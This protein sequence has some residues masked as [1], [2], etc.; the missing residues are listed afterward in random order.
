MKITIVGSGNVAFVLAKL[1]HQHQHEIVE[2]CGRNRQDVDQLSLLTGSLANYSLQPKLPAE[3]Y[4]IA[5]SD[6]ALATL[7]AFDM[8]HTGIWVHSAGSI[9][10]TVLMDKASLTGVWYPLQSLSKNHEQ[11]AAIPFVLTSKDEKVIDTL[12]MLTE[13][14]G[15]QWFVATDGERFQYHIA[16][17]FVNNFTNYLYTLAADLCMDSSIKFDLLQPLIAAT[18]AR[19]SSQYPGNIQT[20]PAARNDEGT[21]QKHMNSLRKNNEAAAVYQQLSALIVSRYHR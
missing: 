7:P 13:S 15:S 1:L 21:M 14:I 20:G 8:G 18:A 12:K 2:I 19:A 5:L 10:Q 9:S 16:A 3:L 6:N 4:L 17:V 11:Q